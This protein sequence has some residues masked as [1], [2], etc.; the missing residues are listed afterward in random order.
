VTGF[1]N[2]P[3]KDYRPSCLAGLKAPTFATATG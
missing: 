2:D 3:T 1:L